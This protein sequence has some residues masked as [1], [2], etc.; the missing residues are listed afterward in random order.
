MYANYKMAGTVECDKD[1]ILGEQ[2]L[3]NQQGK[4]GL[5]ERLKNRTGK[6]S[7]RKRK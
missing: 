4:A 7:I 6:Y 3:Y 5:L 2:Q 1:V